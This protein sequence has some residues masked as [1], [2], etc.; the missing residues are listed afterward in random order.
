MLLNIGKDT[1]AKGLELASC[2]S[3]ELSAHFSSTE[4]QQMLFKYLNRKAT[5]DNTCVILIEL[6][7]MFIKKGL[8]L[9]ESNFGDFSTVGYL[10]NLQINFVKIVVMLIKL[11]PKP[12]DD[13]ND[14]AISMHKITCAL[15]KKYLISDALR[16]MGKKTSNPTLKK[17]S[18]G[19]SKAIDDY[20]NP[21]KSKVN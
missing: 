11:N 18:T 5:V 17:S 6:L 10:H 7:F 1:P 16:D 21:I 13:S 4:G 9:D 8:M 19:V 14:L 20:L 12:S 2:F 3:R 15:L